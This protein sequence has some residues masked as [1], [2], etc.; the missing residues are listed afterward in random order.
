MTSPLSLMMPCLPG[1]NLVAVAATLVE[2]Q[3]Q[4]D[5]A[6]EDI[7]TVHFARFL[8]LDRSQANL[9]PQLKSA[10]TSDSLIISVVTEYDG[11]FNAYIQDFVT[12][13]GDVFDALLKFVVG[14]AAVTPVIN[15]VPA[16]QAYITL[17]DASQHIPN[18][19]LYAAY[20]QTVQQILAAV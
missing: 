16:F 4:I 3:K 15:N 19:T 6:L 12:Q 13:L 8:L 10:T 20:P 17:N 11:D 1:T 9:Q 5:T 18:N 2:A 7:G 14:G